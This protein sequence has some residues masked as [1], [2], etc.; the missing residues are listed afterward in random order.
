MSVEYIDN[1]LK[2]P[3]IGKYVDIKSNN[4]FEVTKD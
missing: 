3:L 4:A 1:D 2:E